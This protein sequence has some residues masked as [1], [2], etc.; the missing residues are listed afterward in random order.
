MVGKEYRGKRTNSSSRNPKQIDEDFDMTCQLLEENYTWGEIAEI[1]SRIRKYAISTQTLRNT[2][3]KRLKNVSLEISPLQEKLRTMQDLDS[4]MFKSMEEFLSSKKGK[5]SIEKIQQNVPFK[6]EE[7]DVSFK[8]MDLVTKV[9]QVNTTGDPRYLK[10][11]MDAALKRIDLINS[12]DL[13]DDDFKDVEI[14]DS[15]PADL[16]EP[17]RSEDEIDEEI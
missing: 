10:L 1:I 13:I 7:G 8:K 6:T 14:D 3:N 9:K 5:K 2:Y 16:P 17:F 4:I 12:I 11:Y 15:P